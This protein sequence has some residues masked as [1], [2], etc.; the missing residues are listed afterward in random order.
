MRSREFENI[1][2]KQM[3]RELQG[4]LLSLNI[5]FM[6]SIFNIGAFRVNVNKP[7]HSINPVCLLF[8]RFKLKQHKSLIWKQH[9]SQDSRG[10]TRIFDTHLKIIINKRETSP[11]THKMSAIT[12]PL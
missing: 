12:Q 4:Q 1:C 8:R 5:I 6:E 9:L 10:S 3:I 2:G 7:D 11:G